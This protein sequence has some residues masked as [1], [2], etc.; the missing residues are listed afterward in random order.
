MAE[1][2]SFLGVGWDFCAVLCWQKE[3]GSSGISLSACDSALLLQQADTYV[4]NHF[5]SCLD[6]LNETAS[7]P[8]CSVL[9]L[10]STPKR[11]GNY[12][13]FRGTK[14]MELDEEIGAK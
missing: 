10:N 13:W 9:V 7:F 12:L 1:P 3:R 4:K 8:I 6:D 11:K 14:R 5:F 2:S